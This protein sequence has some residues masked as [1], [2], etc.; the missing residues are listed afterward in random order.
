MRYVMSPCHARRAVAPEAAHGASLALAALI[1]LGGCAAEPEADPRDG[2]TP[3]TPLAIKAAAVLSVG[4]VA[5]DTIQ[6]FDRVTNPFVL[7]DGRLVVPLSGSADIR[8]FAADGDL[9]ERLGGRGEG[10]GEFLYLSAAW[11]RGDTIEALDS[12]LR[13]VTRFLPDGSVETVMLA[14]GSQRD[15]SAAAGPLG[16]GWALGGVASG[17]PGERDLVVFD[18]FDR[19]GAHIGPL[20]SVVGMARYA[21]GGFGSGP[22]PLSP[23]TVFTSDGTFLYIG[24][25]LLPSIR[26]VGADGHAD[27]EISWEPAETVAPGDAFDQVIDLAVSRAGAERASATRAGLEAARSPDALSVFWDFLVDPEGFVWIQPYEPTAH[28]MA[29]GARPLGG[30]GSGGAWSVL[31]PA[32]RHVGLLEVPEGLELAQ[33]TRTSVV[34]I[35]RDELGVESV[36]VHALRRHPN[37]AREDRVPGS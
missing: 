32:A 23:R 24:D 3:G 27:G 1:A 14:G 11:P 6:E 9:V 12:R 26:R 5:G 15:L 19:T 33:I 21:G 20:A 35:R 30:V 4:V 10:P 7:P 2:P 29:L 22:E 36:H 13:R 31:T 37:R 8:V 18:H 28:A 16:R 17:G 34:G 25:T